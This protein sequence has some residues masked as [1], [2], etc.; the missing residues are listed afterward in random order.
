[1]RLTCHIGTH[2]ERDDH[3]G[4]AFP[5]GWRVVSE[6]LFLRL[7]R[8]GCGPT[9]WEALSAAN[10]LTRFTFLPSIRPRPQVFQ[11]ILQPL[12][13]RLQRPRL[14]RPALPDELSITDPNPLSR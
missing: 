14:N 8:C 3:R 4:G 13:S 6:R 9:I 1:M 12:R 10:Q 7:V 5:G 11:P 2:R